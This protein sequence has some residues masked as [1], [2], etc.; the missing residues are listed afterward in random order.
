MRLYSPEFLQFVLTLAAAVTISS[1][2]LWA[3]S[4][5]EVHP[6]AQLSLV[7]VTLAL[8]RYVW[9]SE[10]G[11]GE[12]PE[13]LIFKDWIIVSSMLITGVLLTLSVYAK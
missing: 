12:V 3:F 6:Y 8:F 10:S 7:P 4:I 9:L 13:D 2:G 5:I 11:K 1:Y